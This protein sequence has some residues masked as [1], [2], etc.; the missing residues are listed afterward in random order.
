MPTNSKRVY[1]LLAVFI[2]ILLSGIGYM[3][4]TLKQKPGSSFLSAVKEKYQAATIVG[5]RQKDQSTEPSPSPSP[6][7]LAP[8]IQTFYG[9]HSDDIAGPKA[10]K[11]VIDPIDPQ[12]DQETTITVDITND[13]DVTKAIAILVTDN[14][15]QS[16]NLKLIS[17]TKTD[18]TWQVKTKINDTYLYSY[19]LNFDLQS[20]SGN[21]QGGLT[22]RQ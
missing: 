13:S 4:Y 9:S 15:S 2:L 8:G 14:D 6:M 21:Y 18:G 19:R 17:G 10:V 5:N 3:F 22:F 7:F 20:S 12:P 16:L 11:I 1:I